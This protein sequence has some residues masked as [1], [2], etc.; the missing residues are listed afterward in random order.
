[1]P[2][3]AASSL[4]TLIESKIETWREDAR[5]AGQYSVDGEDPEA[6]QDASAI[7]D[8]L[9]RCADQL[10]ALLRQE[11]ERPAP[12]E[13]EMLKRMVMTYDMDDS[14]EFLAALTSARDALGLKLADE[15][16]ERTDRE[17]LAANGFDASGH[18]L[19][20][21]RDPREGRQLWQPIATCPP[22]GLFHVHSD[23]A[24]RTMYRSNGV[25]EAT[26]VARDEYGVSR[27]DI[28]VEETGIYGEP[29][30]WMEVRLPEVK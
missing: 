26:G 19:A 11:R 20:S 29:T 5:V 21:L 2:A 12:P 8:T 10:A 7:A 9:S 17:L 24:I 4:T 13:R 30:E 14:M 16:E 6:V 1:M 3:D 15:D 27:P 18:P 22:T 28:R 25:W 23:G